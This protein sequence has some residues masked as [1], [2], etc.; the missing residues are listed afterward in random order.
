MVDK[1]HILWVD[2]EIDLLRPHILYLEGKGYNVTPVNSGEDAIHLCDEMLVDIVLLD[3]MMTGLDGLTTL[4]S[5]KEKNPAIPVI[6]ITKN[7]EEWLMEEA[8]AAQITNYLTKP[9]NPSQILIACKNVLEST[10]IQSD[11]AAKD[12]LQSFQEISSAISSAADVEDWYHI[13]DKLADWSITFDALGD[14]GLGQLLNDQWKE[15][16]QGFTRFIGERYEGWMQSDDRPDLSPIIVEKYIQPELKEGRK[17]VLILMDCLRADHLKAMT[18]QLSTHFQMETNYYVSILPTA[19]PYSRNAIFSGLFPDEL[20]KVYPELWEKMWKDEHSMNKY[21]ETFLKNQLKRNGLEKKSV[22]YHKVLTYES[23]HKL[24]ERIGELKEVD[25]LA[26]VINFIDILGHSRTESEIL[27]EIVPDES[28]YRNAICNWM[29]NAWLLDMLEEISD[30]GHTV[31]FTSDHGSVQV[32]KPVK[33]VGDKQTSAGIRYKYGK[34]LKIPEK[35]GMQIQ[36]PEKFRLPKHE[37]NTNYLIASGDSFFIYPNDYNK[38][39]NYYMN[40]FQHG[41]ISLEEM[42]VPMA[43]LRGRKS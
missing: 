34:N 26:I 4:K 20:Q 8:I 43:I 1:G 14:Q 25:V 42:V 39:V 17:V 29:E 21:E 27:Q 23:G 28:A 36:H 12:Y 22:H 38:Y 18:Q 32:S 19:T 5:I 10:Q 3:E 15:A 37:M 31:F 9:V 35:Y 2:D 7:E 33:V 24:G 6:M 40:S 30:W 13:T 16:N 11:R 41:G